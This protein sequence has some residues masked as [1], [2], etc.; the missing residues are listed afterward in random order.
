MFVYVVSMVS[1][2]EYGDTRIEKIF[3]TMEAAQAYLDELVPDEENYKEEKKIRRGDIRIYPWYA[4]DD[5]ELL[6]SIKKLAVC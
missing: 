3:G 5:G 6:Y 4:D 1:N 2:Q